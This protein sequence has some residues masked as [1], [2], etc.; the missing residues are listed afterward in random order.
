MLINH[1]IKI[2]DDISKDENINFFC[3][4]CTYPVVTLVDFNRNKDYKCCNE[5][6]LTFIESRKEDWTSGWRP[7][8]R[9][10]EEHIKLRKQLFNKIIN[11]TEE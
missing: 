6:Y 7:T 8:K 5:C 1:K 11:I 2:I 4:L 3:S 9:K 10:I